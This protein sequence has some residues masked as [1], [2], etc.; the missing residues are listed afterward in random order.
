V[1]GVVTQAGH[2][3][4][5]RYRLVRPLGKGGFGAVWHAEHLALHSPVA[6]KLL[7]PLAT[8][9]G[10]MLQRFLREARAAA[11]LR[12]PHVVQILDY[13]VD[14]GTPY[15]AME[16]LE[17]ETLE[18]R[19]DRTGRLSVEET[20]TVV[21]QTARAI[22]RAHEA[23]IVHRDLKPA[24][25]YIVPNDEDWLIKVL[26]FGVAKATNL[27]LGRSLLVGATPAG[28]LLG[29]PNYMSPE[30]AEGMRELDFRTDFWAMGVIAYQCLL[31]QQP[32]QGETLGALLSAICDG[33]L[34]VPS[35]AG[36]V[37]VGFDAW[38]ARACARRPQE[39]FASA[40][41]MATEFSSACALAAPAQ[42]ARA[43]AAP[44]TPAGSRGD[45][46]LPSSLPSPAARTGSRTLRGLSHGVALLEAPVLAR[47]RTLWQRTSTKLSRRD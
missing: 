2:I 11:A 46:T 39:R 24:N 45:A 13:G 42:D 21:R 37:P 23:G 31:G 30:Q 38:F 43:P 16:L 44:P 20:Q 36:V 7:D 4:G 3:L 8:E 22:Q 5:E 1:R 47:L 17:G 6:L 29:T 40:K 9:D 32:F 27:A 10:D 26:D 14:E 41:Q 19:L 18:A 35:R 34:P 25:I 33:A 28:T 15:I 12:S